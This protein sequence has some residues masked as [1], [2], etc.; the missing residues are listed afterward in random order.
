MDTTTLRYW[1]FLERQSTKTSG[2][3]PSVQNVSNGSLP[4][5]RKLNSVNQSMTY[6][7]TA[8]SLIFLVKYHDFH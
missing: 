8:P 5:S 1:T 3:L 4:T 2:V 6:G 7:M